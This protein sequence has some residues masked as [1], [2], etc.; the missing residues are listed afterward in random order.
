MYYSAIGSIKPERLI[1]A[2]RAQQ[3]IVGYPKW[4]RARWLIPE[5]AQSLKASGPFQLYCCQVWLPRGVGVHHGSA[6]SESLEQ[7][8]DGVDFV[9]VQQRHDRLLGRRFRRR[10]RR[11]RCQT[12]HDVPQVRSLPG[13]GP[14]DEHNGLVLPV[15]DNEFLKK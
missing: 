14:P 2:R 10:R 8:E 12:R 6:V 5:K 1:E 3:L 15:N 7:D 13:S 9:D 4:A 11:R